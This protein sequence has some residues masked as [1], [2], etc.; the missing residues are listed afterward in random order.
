MCRAPSSIR[1]DLFEGTD[2]RAAAAA[3]GY[4]SAAFQGLEGEAVVLILATDGLWEFV[5]DQVILF[6]FALLSVAPRLLD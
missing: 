6:F 4:G 5:S 3:A 1:C 2:R